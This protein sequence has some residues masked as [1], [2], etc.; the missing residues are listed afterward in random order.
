MQNT[1]T[2]FWKLILYIG[3]AM[4]ALFA[5]A[6]NST[7]RISGVVTD[8]TDDIIGAS[9][10]VVE[11]PTIGTVTDLKGAFTLQVPANA[12]NIEVSYIGY[13][14]KI[15]SIGRN[16]TFRIELSASQQLLDEVVVI[17][18][19]T[20]KKRDVTGAITSVSAEEIISSKTS[21]LTEAMQGKVAGLVIQGTSEPGSSSSVMIRGASSLSTE[22]GANA[23]LY[24]VDGMEV[25]TIDNINPND[26]E[27]IEVLKDAA[28][29]SIYGS[30]SANGV[31][32][33][34]TVQGKEGAPK[35]SLNYSYR[36]SS[37]GH[38]V[39]AMNRQQGIDYINIRNYAAG[40][41]PSTAIDVVDTYN[42]IFMQDN[43]LQ[44]LLF[45]NAP[46]N[47]I[48]LS[49]AGANKNIKYY[50]GAGYLND[51]GI[52]INTY[53]KQISV[54]SNV[55][56][57]ATKALS[58]GSRISFVKTDRRIASARSRSELLTRP[59]NYPIYEL[60]GS[61][62]PVINGRA[63]P[64]AEAMLGAANLDVYDVNINQF[65]EITFLKDFKFRPSITAILSNS[66][67]DDF[68][69]A[70]LDASF[71]RS[72]V[73]QSTTSFSWTNDNVLSYA[74]TIGNHSF[75]GM[76]GLSLQKLSLKRTTVDVT[77]NVTDNLPISYSYMKAKSTTNA[78]ETGNALAALFGRLSYSYQGR[79]IANFNIRRDGS[80]RFGLDR[81]YGTFPSASVG[82][83]F[84]DETFM[85]FARSILDDAKIRMSYGKTGNQGAGNY[86]WQSLYALNVYASEPG[87][88]PSQLEN[89]NLGWETTQQFNVGLDISMLN[90]RINIVADYYNKKTSDVLFRISIPETSGFS[91]VYRNIGNVDNQ[92]F[93]LA[94]NTVNVKTKT[95]QWKTGLTLNFNENMISSVPPGGRLYSNDMYVIDKGF[96]LGTMFGYKALN[97]FSYNESNN[98]D[99]NWNQLTPVFDDNGVF[100]EFQLNGQTY[101]GER[102]QKKYAS[103]TGKIFGGGD[104][105]WDDVNKDGI[106]DDNDRQ[107]IGHGAPKV[108]GGLSNTITYK[109]ISLSAFFSFSFGNDIY[110]RSVA[111]NN[112]WVLSAITRGDPRIVAQS[113]IAPGD[114]AK[115]PMLFDSKV[116]N[117]RQTSSLWIE[118]GSFIRLKN[119]RLSYDF[120]KK[121]LKPL[122]ISSLNVYGMLQDFF[123]WTNYSMFD[124]EMAASGYN[125]GMDVNVY[126]RAKSM[127]VGLNINF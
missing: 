108:V 81:R 89:R 100:K 66:L 39:P 33:I 106:I 1:Q 125:Y 86:P 109:N 30:K 21:T 65:M 72:S 4:T 47:K 50:V 58:I 29:A 45:R 123:T 107:I 28:S 61:F 78:I 23:P 71:L 20:M 85:G 93:E 2:E 7:I 92:G 87:F 75:S 34:T 127:L 124:P 62:S 83:R 16:T 27:S 97:I 44:D 46:S 74:K 115:Y 104:V 8:G 80:S 120:P 26:I 73:N 94:I 18:Y 113:W 112:S 51:Q 52:Q 43:F 103:E 22:A 56:Y 114:N 37:I 13:D 91:S 88:F 84:S 32:L 63:N 41:L 24:I 99:M 67:Y 70:I 42:P 64:M 49:I 54:R 40:S 68:N 76:A 102:Q 110:K 111:S 98:F 79:Y 122:Q 121:W 11:H 119:L 38:K 117:T 9:V 82:W 14:K 96:A 12:R 59:A 60:D 31:I 116:E 126:P 101:T 105:N 118:D 15:V 48:D 95:L 35:I 53:N 5:S 3:F 19:G 57:K 25:T 90:S 55:D 6:Q 69:P 17:G 77:G 10:R 36:N